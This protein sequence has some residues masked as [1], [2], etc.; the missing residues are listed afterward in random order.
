MNI[1]I[2]SGFYS[3]LF[4]LKIKVSNPNAFA[5]SKQF[6]QENRLKI[7]SAR[8]T[9]PNKQIKK[10]LLLLLSEIT[11]FLIFKL[12][13]YSK[14]WMKYNAAKTNKNEWNL[15]KFH[16]ITQRSYFIT[17][18]EKKINN[19]YLV[20]SSNNLVCLLGKKDLIFVLYLIE[21]NLTQ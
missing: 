16:Q 7:V 10:G 19:I 17:R 3:L 5:L 18:W 2:I 20:I 1:D 9:T 15:I 14:K 11:V 4:Q 13:E 21:F 8:L 6:L 12:E